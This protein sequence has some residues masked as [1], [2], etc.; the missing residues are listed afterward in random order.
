MGRER[1]K[2]GR[3]VEGIV[4]EGRKD[5]RRIVD[6]GRKDCWG[7]LVK[8]EMTVRGDKWIEGRKEKSE[9]THDVKKGKIDGK[10]QEKKKDLNN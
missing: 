6:E 3:T 2:E 5:C 7:Q 4:C 9:S 10:S 1:V 8:E